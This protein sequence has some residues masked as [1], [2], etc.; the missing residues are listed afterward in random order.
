MENGRL[1]PRALP[2]HREAQVGQ[3]CTMYID[4]SLDGNTPAPHRRTCIFG[5]LPGGPLRGVWPPAPANLWVRALRPRGPP[6]NPPK[7]WCVACGGPFNFS[8]F[9]TIVLEVGIEGVALNP[10][11]K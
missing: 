2:V 1:Q 11:R 5:D 6:E 9:K 4:F 3:I 7:I 10:N 8:S